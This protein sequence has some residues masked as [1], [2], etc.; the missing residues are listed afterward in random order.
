M[1]YVYA[2]YCYEERVTAATV[3][4]YSGATAN[5]TTQEVTGTA[6]DTS[7]ATA[8]IESAQLNIGTTLKY[9]FN[10][11]TAADISTLKFTVNGTEVEYVLGNGYVEIELNVS[12]MLADIVI[13]VDGNIIGN[14]NL[15]TYYEATKADSKVEAVV[16]A[17]YNYAYYAAEFAAGN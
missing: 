10:L 7:N 15:Y 11:V 6:A 14:Y 13:T 1:N 8:Y 3:A 17:V 4:N 12:D 9:R 16:K 2:S 5:Y